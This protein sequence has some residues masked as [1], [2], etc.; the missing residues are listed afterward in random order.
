MTLTD[1]D[2]AKTNPPL[3]IWA[4]DMPYGERACQVRGIWVTGGK[5]VSM[6]DDDC[7]ACTE[8]ARPSH[9]AREAVWVEAGWRVAHDFTSSLP[10]WLVVVATRHVEAL[11]GLTGRRPR[12]WAAYFEMPQ[13]P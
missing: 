13:L 6:S 10:G 2:L 7:Y 11:D 8:G 5:D 4:A 12:R 1:Q 9:P 3:A